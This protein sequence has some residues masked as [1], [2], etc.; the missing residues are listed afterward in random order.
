MSWW[1][2]NTLQD[3][4]AVAWFVL[5][6]VTVA[7]ATPTLNQDLAARVMELR[8]VYSDPAQAA[9]IL[10]PARRL[11]HALGIDPSK[12]RPSSEALV[13]RILLGKDIY[14]VNTAVDSANLASISHHRPVG[15]YDVDL[16]DPLP[17]TSVDC[18]KAGPRCASPAR[19]PE[20][21]ESVHT[22]SSR[23]TVTLRL[24]RPGEEYAGIGK[25]TIHLHDRP[26]LVDRQ[27]PFGN[28]SSDS[29]RTKITTATRSLLFVLFEP[30]DEQLESV[31]A[32]LSLSQAILLRHVGGAFE[33]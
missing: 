17:M 15:L 11:Y 28:P 5:R 1:I 16:I 12:H 20:S 31:L 14:R 3:R 30:P 9:E 24:G 27:G 10:N 4:V 22:P 13:R 23:E 19:E 21:A 25:E 32:H 6:N 7:Q 33:P 18:R 29:D 26:T 2:D 8:R